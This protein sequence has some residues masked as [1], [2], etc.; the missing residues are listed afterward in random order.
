MVKE[1]RVEVLTKKAARAAERAV[2]VVVACQVER[3][4][5]VVGA[6]E[7]VKAAKAEVAADVCPVARERRVVR[8]EAVVA[9]PV[10]RGERAVGAAEPVGAAERAVGVVESHVVVVAK[11]AERAAGVAGVAGAAGRVVR[12]AKAAVAD[13][14][15]N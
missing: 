12:L 4:E 11:A 5:R 2:E 6:V 3:E 1:E 9:C 7:P 8:A 15:R 13:V 10:E 14:K